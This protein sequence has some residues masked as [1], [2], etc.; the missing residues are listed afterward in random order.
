MFQ[1]DIQT[2]ILNYRVASLL[3][4]ES[5]EIDLQCKN[6]RIKFEI[7][8]PWPLTAFPLHTRN[9]NKNDDFHD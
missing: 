1:S 8:L 5:V 9:K 6:I 3:R 7:N 4:N 2:N